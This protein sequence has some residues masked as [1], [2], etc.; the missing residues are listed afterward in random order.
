MFSYYK[1]THLDWSINKLKSLRDE[2]P[3]YSLSGVVEQLS[4]FFRLFWLYNGKEETNSFLYYLNQLRQAWFRYTMNDGKPVTLTLVDRQIKVTGKFN[5]YRISSSEVTEGIQIALLLRDREGLDF[6]AQIPVSFT[7]QAN[8][9]DLLVETTM[10]FYQ[11]I[12]KGNDSP[13]EAQAA[14]YALKELFEWDTYNRY[15][16]KEGFNQE[17]VWRI[18]FED[19]KEY[20]EYVSLPVINIYYQIWENNQLGFEDA[21][22]LALE[23]WK[24]YYTK[25]WVDENQEEQDRSLWGQGYLS[26][27]IA[28]ACAFGYDRGLR[29]KNLESSYIPQWLIEGNFSRIN[30]L[31]QDT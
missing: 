11:L 2:F 20:A 1:N 26:L 7:E 31:L 16:T 12:A 9:E 17:W 6:Y 4:N 29:L 21:V 23:K 24:V 15:V 5:N 30:L 10:A 27:P 22:R 14:F 18:I 3:E 25:V 8:Q 19:R 28:A 13:K